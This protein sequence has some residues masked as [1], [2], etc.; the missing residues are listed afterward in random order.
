MIRG[1]E[2]RWIPLADFTTPSLS[3]CPKSG[4]GFPKPYVLPFVCP[5]IGKVV[6][7]VFKYWWN[8]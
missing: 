3:A 7:R 2:G 1:E 5:M 8:C 6:V 4:H